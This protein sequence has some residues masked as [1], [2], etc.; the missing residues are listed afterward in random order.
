MCSNVVF[1]STK[2]R[3]LSYFHTVECKILIYLWQLSIPSHH[4]LALRMLTQVPIIRYLE[5]REEIIDKEPNEMLSYTEKQ[6]DDIMFVYNLCHHQNITSPEE[7]LKYTILAVFY[8]KTLRFTDYFQSIGNHDLTQ[9]DLEKIVGGLL[10]RFI[11]VRRF[12]THVISELDMPSQNCISGSKMV[13]L[14]RGL[15][16]SFTLFNHSCSSPLARYYIGNKIVVTAARPMKKG[17]KVPD[18]YGYFF[19]NNERI[20]RSVKIID[21]FWFDCHCEVSINVVFYIIVLS[22]LLSIIIKYW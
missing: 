10:I 20:I 22:F 19:E 12:N 11:A 2:C 6:S 7:C 17:E 3:D 15:F 16:P 5:E 14:G 8:I 1:C 18:T 4:F 21:S 9:L 13:E